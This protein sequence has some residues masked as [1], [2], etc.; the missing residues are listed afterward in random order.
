[1][2]RWKLLLC[3]LFN[4]LIAQHLSPGKKHNRRLDIPLRLASSLPAPIASLLP[5]VPS[6]TSTASSKSVYGLASLSP[7]PSSPSLA[8]LRTPP[9]LPMVVQGEVLKIL[10]LPQP[11]PRSSTI[12]GEPTGLPQIS[13]SGQPLQGPLV[14]GYYPDWA[15]DTFPPEKLDFSRYDWVDFAFAVPTAGFGLEWDDPDAANVLTRLVSAAHFA[16]SKVKLSIGGWTGSRHFSKAVSTPESRQTFCSSILQVY[17]QY[18]LD[19]IDIDWEYPGHEGDKGNTYGSLDSGNF[20]AFLKLLRSTLPP[21]ARISAAV[22]PFPFMG[23]D[24]QPLSDTSGFA[25]VLDWLKET[26]LRPP[27]ASTSPGPNAPLYDACGNSTQPEA[28]ALAGYQAWTQSGFPASKLVLGLPAYGYVQKSAAQR[29]RNRY[30]DFRG[31]HRYG[32]DRGHSWDGDDDDDEDEGWGQ[33]HWHDSHDGDDGDGDGGE[34]GGDWEPNHPS[35]PSASQPIKVSDDE[36][37]IQF[38]DLVKQGALIA[39]ARDSNETFVRYQASGGFERRWDGCSETPFL[40]ST[41]VGQIV[42]YDDPESLALKARFAKEV[43]MLG[44]NIFDIHGDTDSYD[45]VD[46]IRSAMA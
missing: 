20:L 28:N 42:T 2:L 45:L 18:N 27:I 39:S 36:E 37:Q 6:P 7:W 1:M 29:L 13:N 31:R 15:V 12:P 4:P 14:M 9:S 25:S 17:S 23:E 21:S 16:R 33:D 35:G 32:G 43:G 11:P 44:V 26:D 24:G 10:P 34:D 40:R 3:A 8:P 30:F 38:R 41:S 19:G 5:A 46:A 22:Q